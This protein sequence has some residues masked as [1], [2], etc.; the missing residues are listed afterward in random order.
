MIVEKAKK[1]NI[2]TL[3]KI[4]DA[5]FPMVE[6]SISKAEILKLIPVLLTMTSEI[7]LDS[8][9]NTSSPM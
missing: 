2:T 5:V 1:A 4:V 3:F 9:L 7:R 8:R 6:T